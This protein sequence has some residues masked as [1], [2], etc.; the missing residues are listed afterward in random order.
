M[1]HSDS[2]GIQNKF[3]FLEATAA[4]K[5]YQGNSNI[6]VNP[7]SSSQGVGEVK[8]VDNNNNKIQKSETPKLLSAKETEE[9]M[10]A[11]ANFEKEYGISIG[12]AFNAMMFEQQNDLQNAQMRKF[13]S[14]STNELAADTRGASYRIDDPDK[15][16]EKIA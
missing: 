4:K 6:N 2:Y 9:G 5:Y 1:L 8:T 13:L 7:F 16:L 3:N 11:I 15:Y 10:D 12:E 14:N